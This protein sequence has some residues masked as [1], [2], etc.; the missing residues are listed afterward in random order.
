MLGRVTY[1]AMV[2]AIV[3]VTLFT[4]ATPAQDAPTAD[5]IIADMMKLT[6][7]EIAAQ[8]T[9]LKKQA[10]D[11]RAKA[12]TLRDQAAAVDTQQKTVQQALQSVSGFV[13]AMNP[14]PAK[15]V[16][17]KPAVLPPGKPALNFADDIM[18]ILEARCLKCHGAEKRKGGLSLAT[19]GLMQTGGSSGETLIVPGDPDGSRMLQL[20]LQEMD[21]VMPPKGK[22]LEESEL[23]LMQ[24]WIESGARATADAKV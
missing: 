12:K 20:V 18:P 4:T 24:R 16:M 7:A 21:P 22:P 14:A 6:P 13:K 19:Y 9:Q 10:V 5:K 11:L 23:D 17:A 3:A 2:L 15:P 8:L 1:S